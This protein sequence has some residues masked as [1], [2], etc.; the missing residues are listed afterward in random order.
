MKQATLLKEALAVTLAQA[1]S[2]YLLFS[3]WLLHATAG[4]QSKEGTVQ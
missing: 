1:C 4:E 2:K 3:D